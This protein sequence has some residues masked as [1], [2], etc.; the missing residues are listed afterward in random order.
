MSLRKVTFFLRK[1]LTIYLQ[2]IFASLTEHILRAG[3]DG[4]WLAIPAAELLTLA[5]IGIDYVRRK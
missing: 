4:P 2:K 1:H 3:A 5:V